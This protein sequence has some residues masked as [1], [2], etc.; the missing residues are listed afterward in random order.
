MVTHAVLNGGLSQQDRSYLLKVIAANTGLS[1]QEAVARI[2]ETVAAAKKARE[3]VEQ[4]AR[5]AAEMAR[6]SAILAAMM[7]AA[8]SL[9]GLVA[10][11]WASTAAGHDR[12]HR[13]H[14]VIFGQPIW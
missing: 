10:A 9:L 8:V 4:K 6:K 14:L 1:E 5:D 11:V 3:A 13:R 2:D 12:D 7:A